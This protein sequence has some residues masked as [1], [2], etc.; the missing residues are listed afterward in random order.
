ME[1]FAISFSRDLPDPGI[2]PIS[3][4]WQVG[5]LP[6]SL[7]WEA[8]SPEG[9]PFLGHLNILFFFLKFF[10]KSEAMFLAV[11]DLDSSINPVYDL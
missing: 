7:S 4:A 11:K 10:L 6:L 9:V 8:G 1:Y 3:P 5:S 2:K